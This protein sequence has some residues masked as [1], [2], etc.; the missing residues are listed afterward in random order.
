MDDVEGVAARVAKINWWLISFAVHDAGL[1]SDSEDDEWNYIKTAR[2]DDKENLPP[3]S[4]E[5]SEPPVETQTEV[6]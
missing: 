4:E 3:A 2:E 1:D 6:S 5:H